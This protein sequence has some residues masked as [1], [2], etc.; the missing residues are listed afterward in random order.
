MFDLNAQIQK[1]I[2]MQV[3]LI[4]MIMLRQ[5]SCASYATLWWYPSCFMRKFSLSYVV[6]SVYDFKLDDYFE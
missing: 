6:T 3:G 2:T 1:M 5:E 4:T